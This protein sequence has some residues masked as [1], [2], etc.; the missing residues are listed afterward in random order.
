M[1][2]R[3]ALIIA[4]PLTG[5]EDYLPGVQQD[6]QNMMKF[7]LSAAG[8]AWRS[9][10]ISIWEEPPLKLLQNIPKYF[11]DAEISLIVFSGHGYMNGGKNYICINKKHS[12]SL[13]RLATK[14]K[15]EVMIID[16][17]RTER[18]IDHF[19]GIGA[20]DFEF[21]SKNRLYSRRLM[22]KLISKSSK[23][24]NLVLSASPD[25]EAIDTDSGG[26]F[27]VSLM[28]SIL[29][30]YEESMSPVLTMRDLFR[31]SKRRLHTSGGQQTPQHLVSTRYPDAKNIPFAINPNVKFHQF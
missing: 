28:Q 7:L 3:R 8:G 27:T 17:C 25:E 26:A 20:I 24:R 1:I 29:H 6:V 14:S 21:D 11:R 19:D 18:M 4:S 2:K 5:T 13:D 30:W 10:E 22:D 9:N 12:I 23:G 15:R 31:M 16:A